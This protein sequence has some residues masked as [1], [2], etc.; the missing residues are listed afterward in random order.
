M[1]GK[2]NAKTSKNKARKR[3]RL[4]FLRCQCP[5]RTGSAGRHQKKHKRTR[6]CISTDGRENVQ[7]DRRTDLLPSVKR[8]VLARASRWGLDR[9][10]GREQRERKRKRDTHAR[11]CTRP[12]RRSDREKAAIKSERERCCWREGGREE[13]PFLVDDSRLWLWHRGPIR[14]TSNL[15]PMVLIKLTRGRERESN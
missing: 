8:N 10:R 5:I 15:E 12:R 7:S 2:E 4:R 6:T 9:K 3:E 1:R 11:G 14:Y 13:H